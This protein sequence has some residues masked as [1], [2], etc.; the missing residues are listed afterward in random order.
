MKIIKGKMWSFQKKKSS[1]YLN[2]HDLTF[3]FISHRWLL[4][5]T[6][7]KSNLLWRLRPENT[8]TQ[9]TKT[10]TTTKN[11]RASKQ[12]TCLCPFFTFIFKFSLVLLQL[13]LVWFQLPER[14]NVRWSSC[15][16]CTKHH[17]QMPYAH[18]Y[19]C[20]LEKKDTLNASNFSI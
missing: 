2:N 1:E 4:Y 11:K 10:K 16:S 9:T 6:E 19:N 5:V 8:Q 13:E 20:L 17:N 12:K 3:T 7:D 18:T 15:L 14:C